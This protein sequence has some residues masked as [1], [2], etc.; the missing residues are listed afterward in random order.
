MNDYCGIRQY[1]ILDY[2]E[3]PFFFF[4]TEIMDRG[5]LCERRTFSYLGSF[6]GYTDFGKNQSS[7]PSEI[8]TRVE[9]GIPSPRT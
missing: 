1:L 4:L 8:T 5:V 3:Q 6:L 7:L 2:V 9:I